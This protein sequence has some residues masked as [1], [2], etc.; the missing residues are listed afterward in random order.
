M[1]PPICQLGP[2]NID[3]SHLDLKR[4][5]NL[6]MLVSAWSISDWFNGN[7]LSV[8]NGHVSPTAGMALLIGPD[9]AFSSATV[10]IYLFLDGMG[11]PWD[12]ARVAKDLDDQFA[13]WEN[14]MGAVATPTRPAGTCRPNY[15]IKGLEEYI[16]EGCVDEL[17]PQELALWR[18]RYAF[19]KSQGKRSVG[20]R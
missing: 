9:M 17:L 1:R 11:T 3:H 5:Q 18:K 10:E 13:K 16:E 15:T 7:S 2:V 4:V 19:L 6:R 20:S 14:A 12:R 8:Y